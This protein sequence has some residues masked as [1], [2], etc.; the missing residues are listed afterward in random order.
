MVVGLK[1]KRF[2]CLLKAVASARLTCFSCFAYLL[3]E[4]KLASPVSAGK[5]SKHADQRETMNT[6]KK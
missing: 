6:K 2:R 3:M 4:L 1:E 5:K